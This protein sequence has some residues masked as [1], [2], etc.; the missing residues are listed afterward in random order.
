MKNK[1]QL[2]KKA[3]VLESDS[4]EENLANSLSIEM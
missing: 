1:F 3:L 2:K 4:E